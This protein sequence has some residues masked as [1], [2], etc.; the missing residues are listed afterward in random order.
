MGAVA[1]ASRI[2]VVWLGTETMPRPKAHVRASRQNGS[3]AENHGKVS[4]LVDVAVGSCQTEK[5]SKLA[6]GYVWSDQR[7][8]KPKKRVRWSSQLPFGLG[9]M[10]PEHRSPDQVPRLLM[11]YEE[12]AQLANDSV[13]NV[14]RRK[15]LEAAAQLLVL[16]ERPR[17][18]T[19]HRLEAAETPHG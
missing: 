8:E 12:A 6:K 7:A 10:P 19:P 14:L 15:D 18:A 9:R 4:H 16:G 3:K 11:T 2:S 13:E 5:R 1:G 17:E